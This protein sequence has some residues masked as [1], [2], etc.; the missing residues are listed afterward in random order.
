MNIRVLFETVAFHSKKNLVNFLPVLASA[1]IIQFSFSIYVRSI[2]NASSESVF[3]TIHPVTNVLLPG[4]VNVLQFEQEMIWS[5][6]GM[7]RFDSGLST[8]V[9]QILIREEDQKSILASASSRVEL[10]WRGFGEES[11]SA[12]HSKKIL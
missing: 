4:N 9:F 6:F 10:S 11:P 1:T 7:Y 12:F 2:F 5:S 3:P 8:S